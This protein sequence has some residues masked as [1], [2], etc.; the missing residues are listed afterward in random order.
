MTTKH[1]HYWKRAWTRGT[2]FIGERCQCSAE[3]ERKV[4]GKELKKLKKEHALMFAR[5]TALHKLWHKLCKKF[6]S[7]GKFK[8]SGYDLICKLQRFMK[9]HPDV[10]NARVDDDSHSGSDLFFIPH[11]YNS[12]KLGKEYWGTS[13]VY[14]PQN[15]GDPASFFLYPSHLNALILL[16]K[17]L[18]KKERDLNKS[19]RKLFVG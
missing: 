5:G 1:K 15:A 10:L 12:P 16:L 7:D 11:T 6:H 19:R 8:A 14:V 4:T 17:Q 18:Q 13:V 3:R 2:D 9:T